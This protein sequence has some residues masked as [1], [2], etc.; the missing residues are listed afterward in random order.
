MAQAGAGTAIVPY[1]NRAFL[2][3][4]TDED[5]YQQ[6]RRPQPKG[7]SFGELPVTHR[8]ASQRLRKAGKF[9]P[10][11]DSDDDDDDD[12]SFPQLDSAV[13][14]SSV[15]ASSSAPSPPKLVSQKKID[16]REAH[17][18]KRAIE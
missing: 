6:P 10:L 5:G 7:V 4:V 3:V 18:F 9:A 11:I 16:R 13:P 12:T 1:R 2:G 14:A 8:E 15:P 17:N